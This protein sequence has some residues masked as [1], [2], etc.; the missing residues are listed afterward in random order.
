MPTVERLLKWGM[1]NNK[2]MERE[3]LEPRAKLT[4]ARFYGR[5]SGRFKYIGD[6]R[7]PKNILP[8]LIPGEPDDEPGT[9]SPADAPPESTSD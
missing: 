6:P 2:F 4:L 1:H 8:L 5:Y 7:D 3:Y 9:T